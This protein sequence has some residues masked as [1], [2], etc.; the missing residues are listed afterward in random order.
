MKALVIAGAVL[1]GL[2]LAGA[3]VLWIIAIWQT[4]PDLSERLGQTGV[5]VGFVGFFMAFG[6]GAF[7]VIE[8]N[9]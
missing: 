1:G 8:L 4:D 2:L 7:A 5:V 9:D 6:F 3:F